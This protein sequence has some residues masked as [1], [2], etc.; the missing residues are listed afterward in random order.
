MSL[1]IA[2]ALHNHNTASSQSSSTTSISESSLSSS[3]SSSES[4]RSSDAAKE[5]T[6]AKEHRST[7]FGHVRQGGPPRGNR[8]HPILVESDG[9][10]KILQCFSPIGKKVLPE[11]NK[12]YGGVCDQWH[13]LSK[14]NK[15]TKSC[16]QTIQ[17]Q[18]QELPSIIPV[19]ICLFMWF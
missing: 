10:R 9:Q 6:V 17:L 18:W 5:D 1:L 11:F 14:S 3:S 2:D 8:L 12:V 16:W 19:T 4:A 13:Q 7:Q 15:Q